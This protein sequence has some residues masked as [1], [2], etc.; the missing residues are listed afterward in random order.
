VVQEVPAVEVAVAAV[1]AAVAEEEVAAGMARVEE[2]GYVQGVFLP[3]HRVTAA[4]EEGM[5]VHAV[6]VVH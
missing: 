3:W 6:Q 1:A 4:A 5:P 2:A